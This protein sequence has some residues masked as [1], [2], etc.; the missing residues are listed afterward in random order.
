MREAGYRLHHVSR[1]VQQQLVS[2][3]APTSPRKI[4]SRSVEGRFIDGR[5]DR[6]PLVGV[7]SDKMG[8]G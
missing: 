6:T 4:V 1:G 8:E 2:R 3:L 7:H 5:S